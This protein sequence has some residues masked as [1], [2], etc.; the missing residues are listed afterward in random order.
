MHR[1]LGAEAIQMLAER[2]AGE[3]IG[4][5]EGGTSGGVGMCAKTKIALQYYVSDANVL[6]SEAVGLLLSAR[7]LLVPGFTKVCVCCVRVCA[8]VCVCACVRVCVCACVCA[9]V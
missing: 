9:S 8:C 4:E 1:M 5:G 2:G 3:G 7:A 6:Q